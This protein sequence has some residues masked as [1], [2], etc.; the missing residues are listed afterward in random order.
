MCV[1]HFVTVVLL[2][3]C[4]RRTQMQ[5]GLCLLHKMV[6]YIQLAEEHTCT[7][8]SFYT[9]CVMFLCLQLETDTTRFCQEACHLGTYSP[10]IASTHV[11]QHPQP[12]AACAY[13]FADS[14]A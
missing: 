1:L 14:A 10:C 7:T 8:A 11:I 12:R 9:R 5:F 4:I 13:N 6:G 3:R 2:A